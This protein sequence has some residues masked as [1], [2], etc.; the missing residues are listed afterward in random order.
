MT[1]P[2]FASIFN[3]GT[4]CGGPLGDIDSASSI[5]AKDQHQL[6]KILWFSFRAADRHGSGSLCRC[7]KLAPLLTGL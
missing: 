7:G 1:G 3:Q 4:E 6:A 2:A 5:Q